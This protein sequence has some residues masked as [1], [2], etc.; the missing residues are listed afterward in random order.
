MYRIIVLNPG[1]TSTKVAV[2]DGAEK[3][4]QTNIQPPSV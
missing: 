1:S 3:V 2:Y 4:F